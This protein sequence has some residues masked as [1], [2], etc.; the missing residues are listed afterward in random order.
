MMVSHGSWSSSGLEC[1]GVDLGL[2]L[3]L[4][5]LSLE[6]KSAC[7]PKIQDGGRPPPGKSLNRHISTKNHPILVNLIH[8][9]RFGHMTVM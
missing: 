2:G 7:I 3:G 9:S 6:S 4:E 5:A 1:V 8:S